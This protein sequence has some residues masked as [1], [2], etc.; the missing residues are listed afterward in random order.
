MPVYRL[1]VDEE[2]HPFEPNVSMA[3]S[4][5]R[6]AD[7]LEKLLQPPMMVELSQEEQEEW[8][9]ANQDIDPP[10]MMFYQS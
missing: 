7:A 10:F 4:L 2:N 6:I 1:E 8:E 3:I 5:K 9:K